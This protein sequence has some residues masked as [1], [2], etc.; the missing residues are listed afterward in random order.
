VQ[1]F[2]LRLSTHQILRIDFNMTCLI[3]PTAII[4]PGAQ[5]DEGV[6]VGAYAYVGSAVQLGRGS[7]VYHHATVEGN[8]WV[9]AENRIFPYAF[10]G[11]LT[12]DL[13]YKGGNPG[14]RIGDRNTFREYST[15]HMG[16]ADGALTVVGSDNNFLSYTHIAHD[17]QVGSHNIFSNCATLAGHVILGDHVVIGGFSAVHQFCHIGSY[18][19]IGGM[20]KV[21]KDVVPFMIVDGSPLETKSLN[22]IG[23]ERNGFT[24]DELHLIRK[25][26]RILYKSGLNVSQALEQLKL[27]A[28]INGRIQSITDFIEK[29]DRGIA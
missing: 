10:V 13:K 22:K 20:S 29:S 21:V 1:S 3:H 16:T 25:A 4:E 27:L 7:Q 6:I 26:H 28:D 23:L 18:A 12:Q 2:Y 15:V 24:H 5:L 19:M 14:L 8:T 9:G 17:C 11:G